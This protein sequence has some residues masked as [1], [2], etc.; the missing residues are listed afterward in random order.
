MFGPNVRAAAPPEV[1]YFHHRGPTYQQLLRELVGLFRSR[2]KIGDQCDICVLTGSGTLA[3]EAVFASLHPACINFS[4]NG[5]E[6]TKRL[7]RLSNNYGGRDRVFSGRTHYAYAQYET[8]EARFLREHWPRPKNPGVHFADCVSSFPYYEPPSSADV[9]TTVS[10]KQLGG[11]PVISLV[12]VNRNSWEYFKPAEAAYSYLNL[13][14]YA[15]AYSKK[16]E[17]P[18]TPAIAL[19]YDLTQQLLTFDVETLRER[20]DNRRSMFDSVFNKV[21][22]I[23]EGPVVIVR[24]EAIP[25]EL[26]ADWDLYKCPLGYQFFLYSGTDEQYEEFLFARSTLQ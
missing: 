18:H 22:L 23:G 6:F 2:F 13:A 7:K 16:W 19:I 25:T 15:E 8:A 21:Q 9:W 4:Y 3:N 24:K 12:V 11:L 14:R 10:S 5:G 17:S 26:A 1:K 20:I